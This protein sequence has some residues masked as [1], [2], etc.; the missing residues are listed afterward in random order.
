MSFPSL[1]DI[2]LDDVNKVQL[3]TFFDLFE[4]IL[5][6]HTQSEWSL[7][8]HQKVNA[9]AM[10]AQLL[11]HSC[12]VLLADDTSLGKTFSLIVF[13]TYLLAYP[14]PL[15]D[16]LQLPVT[17]TPDHPHYD[18]TQTHY[19]HPR[20]RIL[21]VSR[22]TVL[23]KTWRRDLMKWY[24]NDE[25]LY[26]K[27]VVFF[28]SSQVVTKCRSTFAQLVMDPAEAAVAA[29]SSSP[30]GLDLFMRPEWD[31]VDIVLVTYGT[32]LRQY[33]DFLTHHRR[34]E[35]FRDSE[36][37]TNDLLYHPRTLY[38]ILW[39]VAIFDECQ[40]LKS[41]RLEEAKKAQSSTGIFNSVFELVKRRC[42]AGICSIAD[43][44]S[45][46]RMESASFGAV[47]GPHQ[48][49]GKRS[50]WRELIDHPAALQAQLQR[51]VLQSSRAQVLAIGGFAPLAAIP[52]RE[53]HVVF[54][55]LTTA[56]LH[57][58]QN[59]IQYA[60]Y[61][62]KNP[63]GI[64]APTSA[65]SSS[66]SSYPM[67]TIVSSSTVYWQ[68][69]G[70]H[71]YLCTHPLLMEPQ[72]WMLTRKTDL[73]SIE[74]WMSLSNKSRAIL[75]YAQ[76]YVGRQKRPLIFY[77]RLRVSMHMWKAVFDYYMPDAQCL[78]Y[79]VQLSQQEQERVYDAFMDPQSPHMILCCTSQ[80]LDVGVD[81]TRASVMFF[82]SPHW[83]PAA[84]RQQEARIHRIGQT[85]AVDT[86]VFA[87]AG[88]SID[89]K[90][91]CVSYI[92]ERDVV[93]LATPD[94][95]FACPHF[96]L[97]QNFSFRAQRA[98]FTVASQ[99]LQS[100]Y[101]QTCDMAP[102]VDFEEVDSSRVTASQFD[103]LLRE[104]VSEEE[105]AAL[106]AMEHEQTSSALFAAS[107]IALE[108]G[109]TPDIDPL[110]R[111]HRQQS[112]P[113]TPVAASSPSPS[114]AS[115]GGPKRSHPLAAVQR[116]A[117]QPFY[118]PNKLAQA[119]Q[120]LMRQ[121]SGGS[122]PTL[123][124]SSPSSSSL[125]D[126]SHPRFATP[127]PPSLAYDAFMTT[128]GG[129]SLSIPPQH[130]RSLSSNWAMEPWPEGTYHPSSSHR[131]DTWTPSPNR[132]MHHQASSSSSSSSSS[133]GDPI[134]SPPPRTPSS[135]QPATTKSIIN[136]SSL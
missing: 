44:M 42:I 93:A 127:S 90:I 43:Y 59:V 16:R 80:S 13:L 36:S 82:E 128:G 34:G 45:K 112:A 135:R 32:L 88:M 86:F 27:R 83:N 5:S 23:L 17:L 115:S 49:W 108:E 132:M 61:G 98:F 122:T 129:Q 84:I 1:L 74:E 4:K 96:S 56:Q 40:A 124:H 22:K 111:T 19:F 60:L 73:P 64:L 62:R 76:E 46:H 41:G 125:S 114:K 18:P 15:P 105:R 7:G 131:M 120:Y 91:L 119:H 87:A 48:L 116:R 72:N 30:L 134:G 89:H 100:E 92:R 33:S 9:K 2:Q 107:M 67:D 12:G 69:I 66:T 101:D 94:A 58:M 29:A 20:P 10:L 6:T 136:Y 79:D 31:Q 8:P 78:V 109:D 26:N 68:L 117:A 113:S 126:G 37:E 121:Q 97:Q 57:A 81:L 85:H 103:D 106:A 118:S 39:R 55:R 50:L 38:D 65:S 133:S 3:E 130:I 123:D 53:S 47:C 14:P 104:N 54:C 21:I 52:P 25:A 63:D 95:S 51:F 35:T 75:A 102:D 28:H 77:V 110:Q 24:G 70:I 11:T 71:R 99:N